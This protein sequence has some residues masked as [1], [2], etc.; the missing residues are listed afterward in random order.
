[1]SFHFAEALSLIS[2]VLWGNIGNSD[3]TPDNLPCQPHNQFF[4][5]RQKR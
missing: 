3:H 5:A 4:A 1:M 2:H